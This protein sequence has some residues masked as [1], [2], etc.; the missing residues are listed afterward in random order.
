M[1]LQNFPEYLGSTFERI[2]SMLSILAVFMSSCLVINVKSLDGLSSILN[3]L[4]MIPF[5]FDMKTQLKVYILL[6]DR[7]MNCNILEIE[8]FLSFLLVFI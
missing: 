5:H 2:H 3:S 7:P 4:S 6:R 1:D 8:V